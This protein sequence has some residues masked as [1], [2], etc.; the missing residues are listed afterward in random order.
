VAISI[1]NQPTG[2]S[3]QKEPTDRFVMTNQNLG[4]WALRRR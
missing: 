4:R 2:L 1:Q 3:I